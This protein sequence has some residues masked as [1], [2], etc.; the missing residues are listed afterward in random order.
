VKALRYKGEVLLNL[1]KD[2][3]AAISLLKAIDLLIDGQN[4]EE[5]GSI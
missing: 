2:K 4:E 3:E 5:R 1:G